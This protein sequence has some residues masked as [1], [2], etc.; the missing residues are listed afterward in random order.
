LDNERSLV[1]VGANGSGKTRLGAF[2]EQHVDVGAHRIS[3]QRSLSVPVSI[4]PRAYEQAES[5]LLFGTWQASWTRDQTRSQKNGHR[6]GNEPHV[7][8]LNDY[9]HLLALLFADE[10]R[11]NL[12]YTRAAQIS[13]PTARPPACKLDRLKEVWST[14]MPHR[15]L[16]ISDD[17]VHAA[18]GTGQAYEARHMSDGER[19]TIYLI[20]QSL[21]APDNAVIIIDEPELH[22]HRAIQGRLWDQIERSRPDCTFVYITHDLD[23][24]ATRVTARHLWVQEYDGASWIWDEI[25]SAGTP[26]ALTLQVL[27]SRRPVLFVEGDSGSL[28]VALYSAL[29]PKEHVVPRQSCDKVVEATKAMAALQGLHHVSVRG[30][31]DR[32]RREQDEVKALADAGVVV[33]D[34]AEVENLFC[35][36]GAIR[37]VASQLKQEAAA[38]DAAQQKVLE[39]LRNGLDRQV[40]SRALARVQFRLAGFGPKAG[41]MDAASLDAEL[42]EHVKQIDVGAA[43]AESR[44]LFETVLAKGDYRGALRIFNSKGVLPIVAQSLGTTRAAYVG[45]VLALLKESPD[46]PLATEMVEAVA[47]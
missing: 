11:R 4:T 8:M 29:F 32:D 23:F 22:L 30:V 26:D 31:V 46:G 42:A 28:D 44:A 9:E 27:G 39:D 33:A 41:K 38:V 1:I 3:A 6:W 5:T 18:V 13:V 36:P 34:V 17:R 12:E 10:T 7:H 24:A 21:C 16:R 45:I 19:V 43:V 14:V 15:D 25:G 20:G 40:I 37:A 2:I 35:L 47:G